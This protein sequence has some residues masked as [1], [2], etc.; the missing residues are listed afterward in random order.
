[1]R[2]YHRFL[3]TFLLISFN[4]TAVKFKYQKE[5][6]IKE[7]VFG[8]TKIV[9]STHFKK[10]APLGEHKILIYYKGELQASYK[11]LS[12]DFIASDKT[13]S[14]FVALSNS[15]IPPV[16]ALVFSSKGALENVIYH[17]KLSHNYC[18]ESMV[19]KQW[20]HKSDPGI[21]FIYD[22]IDDFEYIKNITFINCHGERVSLE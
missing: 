17:R 1:M 19:D 11:G 21:E 4:S 2:F 3:I 14:T 6:V 16:A 18:Y 10:S 20:V 5:P 7:F 12:F 22:K 13:N 9:R 8:D 15:Y